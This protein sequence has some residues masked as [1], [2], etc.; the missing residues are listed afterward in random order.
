[1]A[2][3]E[4]LG[5]RTRQGGHHFDVVWEEQT[6]PQVVF[7]LAP[8]ADVARFLPGLAGE[9]AE[10]RPEV[11]G[12]NLVIPAARTGLWQHKLA[13]YPW[14]GR[15]IQAGGWT[16]IKIEHLDALAARANLTRHDLK[17]ISGLVPLVERGEGQLP[18]F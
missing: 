18:L 7:S 2:L 15:T 6:R 13:T 16:F 5:Y 14:L 17:A 10:A 3:G 9:D 12:R 11:R 4:R 8:T 1:L